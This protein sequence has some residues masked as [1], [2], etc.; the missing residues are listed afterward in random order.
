MV[1]EGINESNRGGNKRTANQK[2]SPKSFLLTLTENLE[3]YKGK[4]IF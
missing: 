1:Q 4:S 2:K 3:R